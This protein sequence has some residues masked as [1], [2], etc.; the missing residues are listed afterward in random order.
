VAH[1][2]EA[3]DQRDHQRRVLGGDEGKQAAPRGQLAR[4]PAT[5]RSEQ[6]G[7]RGQRGRQPDDQADEVAGPQD[8]IE[9][10]RLRSSLRRGGRS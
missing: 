1:E 7:L 2:Q 4:R 6:D 8:V 3:R 5:A 10:V 9:E